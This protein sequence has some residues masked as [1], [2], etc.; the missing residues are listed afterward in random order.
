VTWPGDSTYP[1]ACF[2]HVLLRGVAPLPVGSVVAGTKST[3][4][5]RAVVVRLGASE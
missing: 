2:D 5:Y 1:D 4:D 3:S